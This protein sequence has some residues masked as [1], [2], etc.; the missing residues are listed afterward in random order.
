MLLTCGMKF[1]SPAA[2]QKESGAVRNLLSALGTL[3]VLLIGVY[4]YFETRRP[5]F[6]GA[7]PSAINVQVGQWGYSYDEKT[8]NNRAACDAIL[9]EFSKARPVFRSE[10]VIGRFTFQY[11]SGKTDRVPF[12]H[13]FPDGYY[14]ILIDGITY[15]MPI[16]RF[17]KLLKDGGAEVT[18]FPGE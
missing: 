16:D 13:G 7:T 11:D 17:R 9:R 12:L 18:N 2:A 14:S 3:A 5:H 6:S 1:A 15:R 8:I 10:K 4:F